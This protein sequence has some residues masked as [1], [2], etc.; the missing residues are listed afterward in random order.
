MSAITVL[1][2]YCTSL[3]VGNYGLSLINK[4]L[5]KKLG[6][7]SKRNVSLGEF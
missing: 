3:I 6:G 7:G 4:F 1:F 5:K 2:G